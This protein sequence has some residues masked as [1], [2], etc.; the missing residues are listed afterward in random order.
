MTLIAHLVHDVAKLRA[1]SRALNKR[2]NSDHMWFKL[3]HTI[4]TEYVGDWEG[5]QGG[6]KT[7]GERSSEKFYFL[8]AVILYK[9]IQKSTKLVVHVAPNLF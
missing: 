6:R 4:W 7:G 1:T 9:Y 8:F 2:I 3:A 5:E